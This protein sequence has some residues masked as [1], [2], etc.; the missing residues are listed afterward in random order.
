MFW[1]PLPVVRSPQPSSQVDYTDMAFD[2]IGRIYVVFHEQISGAL[3][4]GGP[5]GQTGILETVDQSSGFDLGAYC[6]MA[7]QPGSGR[8][9][10]AY[11]DATRRDLRYARKDP[12]GPWVRRI[13]EAVGDV[14][15]HASISVDGSGLVYIAYRDETNRRLRVAIGRP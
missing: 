3:Y 5:F 1:T 6:A 15:S 4:L 7:V 10:L 12:G 9:H 2:E 11:Y 8:V 13:I 14:G